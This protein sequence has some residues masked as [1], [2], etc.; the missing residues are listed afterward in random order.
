MY[1]RLLESQGTQAQVSQ[2]QSVGS[3]A[4][5]QLEAQLAAQAAEHETKLQEGETDAFEMASAMVEEETAPLKEQIASLSANLVQTK[6][7]LAESQTQLTAAV[8]MQAQLQDSERTCAELNITIKQ[9][10]TRI[11]RRMNNETRC[12]RYGGTGAPMLT[13]GVL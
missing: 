1:Q 6:T 7:Q 3:V 11:D 9:V 5:E 12:R 13:C 2:A 10:R 4:V 8:G